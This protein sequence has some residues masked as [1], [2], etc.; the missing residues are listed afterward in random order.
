M[1]AALTV[2]IFASPKARHGR[3]LGWRQW[4]FQGLLIL[5]SV[6]VMAAYVQMT[7]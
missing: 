1:M 4:V 7:T 6:S 3:P 5:A 2:G